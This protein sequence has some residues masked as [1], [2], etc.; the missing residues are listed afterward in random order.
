MQVT[1]KNDYPS[2]Y[3][4]VELIDKSEIYNDKSMRKEI[5]DKITEWKNDSLSYIEN[6][7]GL[8]LGNI[9]LVL[10]KFNNNLKYI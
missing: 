4:L 2:T 7:I 3:P 8:L 5:E 10:E 9:Y 1:F 6:I